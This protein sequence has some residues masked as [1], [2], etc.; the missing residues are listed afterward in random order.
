VARRISLHISEDSK[1]KLSKIFLDLVE[2]LP[3]FGNE[4]LITTQGIR[5]RQREEA[6]RTYK[7]SRPPNNIAI[8]FL[9]F[10]LFELFHVEDFE[11]L[12]D[13]LI[14]LFPGLNDNLSGNFSVEFKNLSENILGAGGWRYIGR[15]TKE[16]RPFGAIIHREIPKLP[17][18][19]SFVEVK[20]YKILPSIFVITLDVY[21]TNMATTH[22]VDLQNKQYLPKGRF[23]Q[24]IPLRPYPAYSSNTSEQVMAQKVLEWIDRLH[25]QVE[26]CF[27]PF[28]NGHFMNSSDGKNASLPAI[29][30]YSIQGVPEFRYAFEKWEREARNWYES[31]GFDFLFD[32]Y[33]DGKQFFTLSEYSIWTNENEELRCPRLVVLGNAYLR[34]IRTD[35]FGGDDRIA[36]SHYTEKTLTELLP[37]LVIFEFLSSARKKVA[38]LRK[39]AFDRMSTKAQLNEQIRLNNSL[40]HEKMLIDRIF[41]EFEQRKERIQGISETLTEFN[42]LGLVHKKNEPHGLI[43]YDKEKSNWLS[44]F[45]SKVARNLFVSK[46]NPISNNHSSIISSNVRQN[47]RDELI[48]MINFRKELLQQQLLHITTSFSDYLA[49][50][51]MEA[52]YSLQKTASY[53][54]VVGTILAAIGLVSAWEKIEILVNRLLHF[55]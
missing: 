34:S 26:V 40:R 35:M 39:L 27:K 13:G 28:I 15:V 14:R 46:P 37:F 42:Y 2:I 50:R 53:A 10:R 3:N 52:I 38:L 1:Y 7:Q 44:K 36:V 21:L 48:L 22:L 17:E 29:E 8:D 31:L 41:M 19:V 30:V 23:L 5:K 20:L 33:G 55:F 12:K 25:Y 18:E 47:L 45:V 9:Y 4:T 32:Y 6:D 54:G 51:N 16:S 43:G 24:L 49:I 11:R